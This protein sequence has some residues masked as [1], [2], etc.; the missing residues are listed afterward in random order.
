[1]SGGD[2]IALGEKKPERREDWHSSHRITCHPDYLSTLGISFL[3]G[4]GF[5]DAD[6]AEAPLVAIVNET[7]ARR[8]WPQEDPLG[9]HFIS[10]FSGDPRPRKVIGVVEDVIFDTRGREREAQF[11]LPIAQAKRIVYA[12]VLL[13]FSG[14]S[15]QLIPLAKS[16]VWNVD[17]EVPIKRVGT[18]ASVLQ[19]RR[20]AA[21][22]YLY[23]FVIFSGLALLIASAGIYGVVSYMVGRRTHEFGVRMALGA[24]RGNI[25]AMVLRQGMTLVGIGLAVGLLASYWLTRFLKSFLFEIEPTDPATFVVVSLVLSVVA[26]LACYVPARRAM[27]VDPM[28]ALRYE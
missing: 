14:D 12:S 17:A 19:E 4:R 25:L 1:M 8:F 28:T 15:R 23:L 9:K 22:F 18:L 21:K 16:R 24:H 13:R 2:L 6:G 26:L 27:R 20:K 3:R 5:T 10:L 7:M 11:Y